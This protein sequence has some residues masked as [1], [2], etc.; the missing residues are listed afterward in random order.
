[1]SAATSSIAVTEVAQETQEPKLSRHFLEA[2]FGEWKADSKIDEPTPRVH[3]DPETLR[4][5]AWEIGERRAHSAYACRTS[6]LSLVVVSPDEAFIVWRVADTWVDE[7]AK[8]KGARW[9]N[10]RLVAR[11]YDV[12]LIVWNGLNAHRMFDV[13]LQSTCGEQLLRLR[14]SGTTQIAEV[15]Y[16]LRDGEFVPAARSPAT[17]FPSTTSSHLHES[18]ALYVDDRLAPEPVASPWE[19]AAYVRERGKPQLRTGLRIAMLSF[20]AQAMGHEGPLGTFVSEL[21]AAL[22]EQGQDVHLFVPARSATD[23][24]FESNGVRYHPL[25]LGQTEGP[26]AAALAF[27]RSLENRLRTLPAFD[28]FHMQEW[29]TAVAPWLGTRPAI[30]AMTSTERARQDGTPPAIHSEEIERVERETARAFECL[31]VPEW[32][33][34]NVLADFGVDGSAVH[35]FP[36]E[37]RPVD[38]WDAP[39]DYGVVK[40]QIGLHPLDR[41][42]LFVGPL[43]SAAGPDLIVDALPTVLS[44]TPNVRVAFVGCGGMQDHVAHRARQVGVAHAVRLLGHRELARL[45]PLL[46]SCE[47]LLMPA[48]RRVDQDEGVVGLAR[49][50]GRAV[51]TTH[52]GP[53]HMVK[54]EK[55]G[56]VVYDNPPSLVW[57]LSRLLEDG[58]HTQR[59]GRNGWQQGER[60]SWTGLARMYSDICA[61]GF[62][63]L[64]DGSDRFYGRMVVDKGRR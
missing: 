21:A 50:A 23:A 34:D 61:Q 24:D 10:A 30:L 38:E 7:T 27:S 29:M 19:G 18:A 15:G 17:V 46:R 4:R 54:H 62:S 58:Q 26:L 43:E 6:Y 1:M 51:L 32:L 31:L 2:G 39:L 5:H 14:L 33:R 42:L 45:V 12:S 48:R 44:R 41:L 25:D 56:L 59:M 9:N 57:G 11:F 52:G 40:A 64:T 3:L 22:H 13:D 63:E 35:P 55:D 8:R 20:Q 60:A 49:R 53:S 37:G 16:R 36:M 28:V 47:A